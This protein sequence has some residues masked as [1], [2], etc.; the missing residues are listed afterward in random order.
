[1]GPAPRPLQAYRRFASG[2]IDEVRERVAEVYC[3]HR[4]DPGSGVRELRAWQDSV[5]LGRVSVGMMSY[6][7]PVTIDP[8]YLETFFLMM[9]PCGGSASIDT[10][11]RHFV[12]DRQTATLLSPDD[13]VTM[14]WDAGCTKKMLR[15]ERA[16]ME[17][18][19]ARL[20][21]RPLR[22][23]LRFDPVMRIDGRALTWWR[24]VDLLIDEVEALGPHLERSPSVRQIESLLLTSILEVQPHNHTEALA[25]SRGSIAPRHVRQVE[26]YIEAHAREGIDL[27]QLVEV[28]GVSAR[29][30]FEGFQRFRGTSPMAYLRAVRLRGVREALLRGD[31]RRTVAEIATEWQFFELGRFA[32]QYRQCYGETPSQT[33]RSAR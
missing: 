9:L 8:G 30:L 22:Q 7:A 3:S 29:T 5:S 17:Q 26:R 28:S 33:L 20:L 25:Q 13:R 21:D 4:L 2:D 12:A 24:Y 6:G 23:P 16:A 1:M 32:G 19:L 15:I 11:G 18:H 31:R 27:A 14:Q 10:G